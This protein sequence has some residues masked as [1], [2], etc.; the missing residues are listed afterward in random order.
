MHVTQSAIGSFRKT[1]LSMCALLLFSGAVWAQNIQVTGKVT[2]RTGAPVPGVT[3][4]QENTQNVVSSNMDGN[5][6]I[7]VPGNSRLVFSQVGMTPLTVSVNNRAIVDVV[8][9]EDNTMLDELVVTAMGIRKERKALG[10]AVQDIKADELMKNKSVNVLNSLV[11][12]ISGVNVTQ[13]GGAAGAGSTMII[14]GGTSLERD[15]QPLF[16]VDGIIY[17]NSSPIGGNSA[18]DGAQRVA[19]TV[20]NRVM[21]INP[22]DIEN[23]SVLKGASAAALYGSRAANGVVIITTKKGAQDGV[24][25]VNFSSKMSLN[26]VN[27]LPEQQDQYM[28]G[29][30]NQA[31]VWDD[32]TTQSWGKPFSGNRIYDNYGDFFETS[33]VY[34]NS[35]NVSGGNKNG[36]FFV[37][38]SRFDQNGI[39]PN[40]NF[41]KTTFRLN[42]EQK[43]GRLTVGA[44]AA[45]SEA[46]TLKTLTSQGLWGA[47]GNGIMT[48]LYTWARSEDMS[49]YLN[50]DG[51]KYRMFEGRQPLSS[52]VDNPYWILNKNKLTDKTIRFTGSVNANF[53]VADWFNIVY[54]AGVDR[55][56][57]NNYTYIAPGAAIQEQYQNGRL[58]DNDR[59]FQ[60]LNSNL[61]LMFNKKV[62]DFDFNL[63]LG[64]SVEDT[65]SVVDRRTGAFSA[66]PSVIS[67]DNIPVASKQ[68]QQTTSQSRLVGVYGEFRA[69]YKSIAYLTVTGRNDWT[70]TLP[71]DN[72][73]YFYPSVSGSLVFTELMPKNNVL[74]F[75]KLRAS[76][77]QVGKDTSPYVTNTYLWPLKTFTVGNGTG[78][79]WQRGNPYLKPEITQSTEIGL[80]LRFFNGRLGLDYAYYNN[81]SINQ[82]I[83]PRLSQT[84]GYILLSTNAGD[85]T[86]QGM[87]LSISGT[88][89]AKKDFSW[90]MMLNI[91][92]NRGKLQNLITGTSVLYVTDVQVGTAKAASFNGG[93][94]MAISGSRWTR[95]ENGNVILDWDTGMPTSDNATTYEVG[96]REPSVIGGLTNSFRY[97]NLSFS[98][99]L[100]YRIGGDIYN[101]T[102]N[103]MTN[104][105]MSLRSLERD[106]I[107]VT[108]V[109]K[110]PS[111]GQM[112]NVSRTFESGKMYDIKG[113]NTS[114]DQIIRNYWN[115]YFPVETAN[116]LVKTNWLRLRALSINYSLP[117]KLLA[118][119]KVLKDVSFNLTGTNLWLLTNYKGLDPENSV[120][121]SGVTGSSSVGIDYAG[122]PSTAGVSFGINVKF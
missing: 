79:N 81:K 38:A 13:S 120:A 114:G 57:T 121:G 110:N 4:L 63:L 77:A 116:Y 23:M 68:F 72:R 40:T 36:S 75:G 106:K 101:G 88:P 18:F 7:N 108:G 31:G 41:D 56:T 35:I 122:V 24:V 51:T 2:D 80:E 14:R 105:G 70:S 39:V 59:M 118:K 69:A 65:K 92:G 111:T 55:Y 115:S 3:V 16:V 21:D 95:D 76:W 11:G 9:D 96:N 119:Q 58:S 46:S 33:H 90:D 50:E 6:A 73:S 103:I 30:Y 44:N 113:Q 74:S 112:E 99:L 17:D 42:G 66:P 87:E 32:F 85:I 8:M 104:A 62:S 53:Q 27:R 22:E 64:H 43:F 97:K 45:Y 49:H 34:D 89:I 19:T 107:T 84:T 28:R 5:Y 94:Y 109:S 91:S 60:Y 82:I 29:Y 86:N 48:A 12:K 47:G 37:S 100:D 25:S 54:R 102:D 98:I 93:N 1:L 78:N 15:N 61:M 71:L 117:A 67:Y 10:Y 52:D 26:W 83:T 20:S